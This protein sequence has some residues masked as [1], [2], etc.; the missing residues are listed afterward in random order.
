MMLEFE[1][2]GGF[3]EGRAHQV[4]ALVLVGLAVMCP[5]D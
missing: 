5:L 1:V 2:V 3:S 4:S